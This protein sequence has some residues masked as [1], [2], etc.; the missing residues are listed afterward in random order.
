MRT[1]VLNQSDDARRPARGDCTLKQCAR[2]TEFG[3]LGT[4]YG[5]LV[6]RVKP[7]GAGCQATEQRLVGT[8]GC[9]GAYLPGVVGQ[10]VG[11]VCSVGCAGRWLRGLQV[12]QVD[13]CVFS[14]VAVVRPVPLPACA[15]LMGD[16]VT[17]E[18]QVQRASNLHQDEAHARHNPQQ[19][20]A[21]FGAAASL[22]LVLIRGTHG[23][24]YR[25]YA[26]GEV[27]AQQA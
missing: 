26:P 21:P 1:S 12:D 7:E 9:L 24:H 25:L 19:R 8:Q 22:S 16:A 15:Y 14:V 11:A 3:A 23:V 17:L 2:R 13:G 20:R 27:P 4:R 6:E 5:W 18:N 10:R